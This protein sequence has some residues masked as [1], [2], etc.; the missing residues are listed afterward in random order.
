[1]TKNP[2]LDPDKQ[3]QQGKSDEE[4][5]EDYEARR[6]EEATA[7][8]PWMHPHK[9]GSARGLAG[10]PSSDGSAIDMTV[11]Y[12]TYCE[13]VEDASVR[14]AAAQSKMMDLEERLA[15]TERNNSQADDIP[16]VKEELDAVR[17]EYHEAKKELKHLADKL[18]AYEKKR[19]GW[20]S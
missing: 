3:I 17:Y 1:M 15:W 14:M 13:D 16:Y 9:R 12:K 19:W 11:P 10:V 5:L 7:G 8:S 18:T 4:I 6:R 2:F 20:A